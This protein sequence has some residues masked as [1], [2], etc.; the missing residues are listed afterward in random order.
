MSDIKISV[1][2]DCSFFSKLLE[3]MWSLSSV[4]GLLRRTVS[5]PHCDWSAKKQPFCNKF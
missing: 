5:V 1:D 3:L 2:S 4:I